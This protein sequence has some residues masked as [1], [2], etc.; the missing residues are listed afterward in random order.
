MP[1]LFCILILCLY[2]IS[3]PRLS[4]AAEITMGPKWLSVGETVIRPECF[5]EFWMDVSKDTIDV[6]KCSEIKMRM[7]GDEKQEEYYGENLDYSIVGKMGDLIVLELTHYTG[8]NWNKLILVKYTPNENRRILQIVR[9]LGQGDRCN[10]GFGEASIK[11][12]VLEYTQLYSFADFLYL[13]HTDYN[14]ALY[15]KLESRPTI[16]AASAKYIYTLQKG[17][18]LQSVTLLDGWIK[19]NY[20]GN[21]FEPVSTTEQLCLE[22]NLKEYIEGNGQKLNKDELGE[23]GLQLKSKCSPSFLPN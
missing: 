14:S 7:S 4:H 23:L 16:C 1:K 8:R 21:V 9:D 13:L 6:K 12:G 11:N 3:D 5:Y 18:K 15:E 19:D 20:R 10:M 17:E 2:L 22:S